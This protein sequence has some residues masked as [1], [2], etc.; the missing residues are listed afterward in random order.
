MAI[1]AIISTVSTV[2]AIIIQEVSAEPKDYN[3]NSHSKYTYDPE[4]GE[5]DSKGGSN[6]NGPSGHTNCKWSYDSDGNYESR[7]K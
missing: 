3:Y 1:I 7:C 2:S 5:Y 6:E 4:T